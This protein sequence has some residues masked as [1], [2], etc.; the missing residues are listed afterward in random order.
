[1]SKPK[2]RIYCPD[3]GKEKMLFETEDKANR[4]IK[5]NSNDITHGES[6]RAY[7]CIACGGY[8]ISHKPI[9]TNRQCR[10]ERVINMYNDMKNA[11]QKLLNNKLTE[12]ADNIKQLVDLMKLE[13]FTTRKDVN[14][15][16]NSIDI[17]N[18][19]SSFVINQARLAYYQF[20]KLPSMNKYGNY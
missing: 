3:C 9:K 15:F 18:K 8:H 1:M 16:L 12:N 4:F 14:R 5:F 20:N 17:R 11:R 7:Y 13:L 19:F 2:N 10:S 6:L